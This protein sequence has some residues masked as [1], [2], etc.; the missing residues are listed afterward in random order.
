MAH[1]H[2]EGF[3]A[4]DHTACVGRVLAAAEAHCRR[5]KLQLT[6]VRRRVLEILLGGHK[7]Q[8]AYEVLA[9]LKDEGLG[10]QPPVAYRALAFL[11]GIG[12]VHRIERLNAFIACA[13]P[14]GGH[15]PAFLIC[16]VC[17]NV[18]E[19]RMPRGDNALVQAADEA[20]FRIEA[21]VI[22]AVGLCPSCR[23]AE[24]AG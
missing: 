20:G 3:L 6:P 5:N 22:E 13:E 17:H 2:S 7:A 8:G 1:M 9:R 14:E 15:S 4:H 23:T 12:F 19:A 18:A 21:A 11:T 16:R 24:P 10:S